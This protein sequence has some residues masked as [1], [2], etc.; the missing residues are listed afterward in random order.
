MKNNMNVTLIYIKDTERVSAKTG[1]PFTSRSIKTK[2][3]G[4]AWLS[5]FA[6]KDN[7]GWKVGDTVDIDVA[8]V[9]KD[10][11]IYTNFTVPKK[12][13]ISD[14]KLEVILNRITGISLKVESIYA[15]VV[16]KDKPSLNGPTAFDIDY[17][18]DGMPSEE[19]VPF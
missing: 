3:H 15:A 12:A 17:P 7:A 9:E 2:E 8:E 1:K 18:V 5:G 4:E 10:G 6:N 16:K 11:K 14:E 13:D 19:D